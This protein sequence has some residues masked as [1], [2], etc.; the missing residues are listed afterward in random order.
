[1]SEMNHSANIKDLLDPKLDLVFKMIFGNKKYP[2]IAGSFLNSILDVKVKYNNREIINIEIQLRNEYN[3]VKRCVYYG[4]R[5][6]N[7]QLVQ[8]EGFN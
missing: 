8:G 5:L 4:S 1:M 6:I 2:E 3:I 7:S